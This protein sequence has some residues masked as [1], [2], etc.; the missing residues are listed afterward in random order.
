VRSANP[1]VWPGYPLED[2]SDGEGRWADVT[3]R[4]GLIAR[5]VGREIELV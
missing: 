4:L 1:Y 5:L 3:F 2:E